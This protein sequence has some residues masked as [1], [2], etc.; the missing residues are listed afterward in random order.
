MGARLPKRVR[1]MLGR[2]KGEAEANEFASYQRARHA[3]E[4]R[5]IVSALERSAAHD[6]AC[7]AALGELKEALR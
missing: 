4:D 6:R 5:A 7:L 2:L 1:R 3:S